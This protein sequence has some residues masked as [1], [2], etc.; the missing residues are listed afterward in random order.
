ME[1]PEPAQGGAKKRRKFA[2]DGER[3]AADA[4][5]QKAR[6]EAMSS[7]EKAL[8][9]E[10][11]QCRR[12]TRA[13][14]MDDRLS[15]VRLAWHKHGFYPIDLEVL[16]GPHEGRRLLGEA[17]SS[18]L[19]FSRKAQ[20][21][22]PNAFGPYPTGVKTEEQQYKFNLASSAWEFRRVLPSHKNSKGICDLVE[23]LSSY[24]GGRTRGTVGQGFIY[25]NRVGVSRKAFCEH[26]DGHA[27]VLFA[28][29][30]GY[31]LGA[32]AWVLRGEEPPRWLEMQAGQGILMHPR[33]RH[34][35]D[36]RSDG[37][38]YLRLGFGVEFD[39]SERGS[40]LV[41]CH[42]PGAYEGLGDDLPVVQ[43]S[44]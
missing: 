6:R 11:A 29:E 10:K 27:N 36:S 20:S 21:W 35:G 18:A 8:E 15:E 26:F 2:D 33:F 34:F 32:G 17:V 23:A 38:P 1:G 9:S 13:L 39:H 3:Q 14:I 41:G 19:L 42:F 22:M 40:N 12:I 28:L 5:R 31:R 30:D 37:R 7:E 43:L 44:L 25:R 4:V 16:F 24:F